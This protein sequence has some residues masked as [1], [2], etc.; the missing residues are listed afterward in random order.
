MSVVKSLYSFP[1]SIWAWCCVNDCKN[2]NLILL[3]LNV[4]FLSNIFGNSG[5]WLVIHSQLSEDGQLT[6]V[7]ISTLLGFLSYFPSLWLFVHWHWQAEL[8]CQDPLL[9]VIKRVGKWLAGT[10]GPKFKHSQVGDSIWMGPRDIWEVSKM[11]P[12][13]VQEASKM[14]IKMPLVSVFFA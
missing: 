9:L 13:S 12:R 10:I 2:K 6:L 11:G 14:Q 4:I 5:K 8:Q 3:L 7:L 1:K